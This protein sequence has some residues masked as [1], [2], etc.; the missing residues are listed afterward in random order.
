MFAEELGLVVEVEESVLMKVRHTYECVGV[1][2]TDI[3]HAYREELR[4]CK[5]N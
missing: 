5:V 1:H 4:K 3:G 2:C